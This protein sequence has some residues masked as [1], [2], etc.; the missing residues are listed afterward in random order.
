MKQAIK[1]NG[2]QFS[3]SSDQFIKCKV[4]LKCTFKYI[5]F[6]LKSNF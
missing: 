3:C 5:F 1:G 2:S 4:P 6:N